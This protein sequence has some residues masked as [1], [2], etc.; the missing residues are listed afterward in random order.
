MDGVSTTTSVSQRSRG[1]A[2]LWT[3]ISLFLLGLVLA[4]VQYSLKLL[5][6]PWYAPALATLGAFLLLCSVARRATITRIV[7]LAVIALLAVFEWYFL[8]SLAKLPGYEGPA[9]A[10]QKVPAFQT[11]L[12]DGRAFSEKHLQTGSPTVL[13]FFRGRW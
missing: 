10:G 7:V 2:Y 9:Q 8:I 12:A 5:I 11:T 1:R 6:V 4:V 13:V 3:G